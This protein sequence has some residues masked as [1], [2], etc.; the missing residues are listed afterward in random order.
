M[1][2]T[3]AAR[4]SPTVAAWVEHSTAV[5][6]A[7]RAAGWIGKGQR[8]LPRALPQTRGPLQTGP[9]PGRR[10]PLGGL[11]AGG[12]SGRGAHSTRPGRAFASVGVGLV[13]EL[14]G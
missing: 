7:R 13:A 6:A 3:S 10:C 2:S 14:A 12:A 11:P 4:A 1:A 9:R 5:A 8:P